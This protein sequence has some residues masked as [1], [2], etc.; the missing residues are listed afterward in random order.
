M[1]L[2]REVT[3]I[4]RTKELEAQG[5]LQKREATARESTARSSAEHSEEAPAPRWLYAL[6]GEAVDDLI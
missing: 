4:R 2:R 3:A 5:A 1:A 6:D